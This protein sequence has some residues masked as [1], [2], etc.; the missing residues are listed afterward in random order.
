M[1]HLSCL[2]RR[3]TT[4]TVLLAVLGT[5]V[6]AQAQQ[7]EHAFI[8]VIDG[9]RASEGFEDPSHLYV[10]PLWD[11]LAP[12]G[13]LLTYME[14]RDQPETI[15]SHNTIISGTYADVANL[16]PYEGRANFGPRSPTL[17]EAYRLATGATADSCWAVGNTPLIHDSASSLMPGYGPDYGASHALDYTGSTPD[18]FAWDQI[19]DIMADHEVGVML[20][21]LHEVDRHAHNGSWVGYTDKANEASETIVAFWNQLQ[22]DPVYQ[23]NT[24]LVVATDHGRHLEGVFT[25]WRDHGC[26]CAGCRQVFML[27]VGPGVRQ[28]IVSDEPVSTLDIAPTVAHMMGLDFPY[29]RGRVLTEVL[30]S[31]A[32]VDPGPGGAFNPALVGADGLLVRVSELQDPEVTDDEGAHRVLVEISEDGGDSWDET[33][34]AGGTALQYA[35]EVWT[36]GEVT[37]V[38]WLEI[39]AHGEEWSTRVRRFGAESSDWEDVLFEAMEGSSTPVGN[40]S[41]TREGDDLYLMELN[42]RHETLRMWTSD[43]RGLSWTEELGGYEIDRYFPRDVDIVRSGDNLV[44]AYSSHAEGPPNMGDLNDNT[45]IYWMVSD[46][47]GDSWIG[48]E[49]RLSNDD[50]PS[51]TPVIEATP[52]GVLHI[53]WADSADGTFQLFHA[54]STD[55]G[56]TFSDPVQ[57]T[58]GSVGSWEP[59][60]VADGERLYVAWSQFDDRDEATVHLA[61]LEGD[62]LVEERVLGNTAVARTPFIAPLGDCTSMITWTESDLEG[63]WELVSEQVVTAGTPATAA[64]GTLDPAE[65]DAGHPAAALRLDIQI[66]VSEGDRGVDG[67]EV[68]VPSQITPAGSAT[69]EVDGDLVDG[70]A[71]YETGVLRFEAAELVDTDGALLTLRFEAEVQADAFEA[72][73]FAV[74]LHHGLESCATEVSGDLLLD[75][76]TTAGDDDDDDDVSDDDDSAGDDDGCECSAGGRLA[77]GPAALAVLLGLAFTLRRR[78]STR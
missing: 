69:L 36:D 44:V 11:E 54:E 23:D 9:L 10:G 45:E 50:A 77:T 38:A 31:G 74:T 40:L 37:V 6:A 5:S 12:Q 24:V 34:T 73:P 46:D 13:S 18:S 52:D 61:A 33:L 1:Q 56:E 42:A 62:A 57:L 25:G 47:D 65:V 75:G 7:A 20:T 27:V 51:I 16:S 63:A 55:D 21:N 49:H 30:Q 67:I 15:P 28:G 35:P 68:L 59:A 19:D 14:V 58:S 3:S 72:A 43:D 41:L 4:L 78:T 71:T 8:F 60:A 66:E 76:V 32:S 53:V 22:A 48:G 70:A 2:A 17:F 26:S 64:T 39:M 29:H